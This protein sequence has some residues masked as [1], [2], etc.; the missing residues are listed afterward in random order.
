M[1]RSFAASVVACLLASFVH[2]D[3]PAD[4]NVVDPKIV[5]QEIDYLLQTVAKSDCIFIRN[6]KEYAPGDAKD[7]LS[8]KRDRGKKYFSTSEEFVD[9]LAS[10]SSW[11]GKPYQIRC[12]E[13]IH[14]AKDWFM[15]VLTR[16]R[17][18]H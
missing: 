3:S 16:Y 12:G 6:G 5:D 11:S 10:S 8:M 15:A 13:E 9:R 4:Q 7:H 17:E 18:S 2:A 14:L 1:T